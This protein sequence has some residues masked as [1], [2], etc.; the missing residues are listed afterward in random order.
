MKEKIK[1]SLLFIL[2]I[3]TF[4]CQTTA[5]FILGS[6]KTKTFISD[7]DYFEQNFAQKSIEK[8]KLIIPTNDQFDQLSYQMQSNSLSVYYGIANDYFYSGNQLNMKSCSGQFQTLYYKVGKDENGLDK[9]TVES[10][11]FLKD[12]DLDKNKKT[13]IFIYSYK[14]G[15]MGNSKI[16]EVI[17]ELRQQDPNFDYRIISLDKHDIKIN[18]AANRR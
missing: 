15:S 10:N 8:S 12:F 7:D 16:F 13:A 17:S 5:D 6:N 9:Q 1:Y 18:T 11:S 2:A 3:Q 14:L 4:S